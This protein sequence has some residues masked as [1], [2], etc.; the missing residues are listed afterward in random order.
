MRGHAVSDRLQVFVEFPGLRSRL[1][2]FLGDE[3]VGEYLTEADFVGVSNRRIRLD[4]QGR[5]Q[6]V[7]GEADDWTHRKSMDGRQ[8]MVSVSGVFARGRILS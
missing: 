3:I 6:Q 8:S 5:D 4:L 2:A 7:E 1:H